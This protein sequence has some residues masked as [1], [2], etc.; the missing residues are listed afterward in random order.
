MDKYPGKRLKGISWR[1]V[2]DATGHPRS[3]QLVEL[4]ELFRQP[5]IAW[6]NVQYGDYS[7]DIAAL[8]ALGLEP[9]WDD[10][11]VDQTNDI[12][13]LAAQLCAFDSLVSISN[14]T[15]HMAGALGVDAHLMLPK[16]RP[17]IWYWGYEG[18]HTPWYPSITIHRNKREDDWHD[19]AIELARDLRENRR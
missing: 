14:T 18:D 13:G 1:T 15:V 8:A 17:V 4:A 2:R 7:A 9:P 6:L 16:S 12:D 5:D 10:L 3:I 11:S 19:F